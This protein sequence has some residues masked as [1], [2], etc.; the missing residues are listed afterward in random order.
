[1]K[2]GWLIWMTDNIT[3]KIPEVPAGLIEKSVSVPRRGAEIPEVRDYK[4]Q[5]PEKKECC[6]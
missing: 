5:D 2:P 6:F 1:M 3:F 4:E